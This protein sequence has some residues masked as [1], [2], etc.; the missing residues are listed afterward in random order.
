MTF[1]EMN[2]H[3]VSVLNELSKA[4]KPADPN[5]MLCVICSKSGKFFHG[6]ST[7][8]VAA[9]KAAFGAMLATGETA[10]DSLM[11]YNVGS[12]S[13]EMPEKSSIVFIM[14]ADKKNSAASVIMP[15]KSVPFTD[16]GGGAAAAAPAPAPAAEKKNLLLDRVNSLMD[17]IDEGDDDDEEF[18]EE[19]DTKKKKKKRFGFF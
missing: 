19:L 14:T 8:D 7:E 6:F 1:K 13:A 12:K 18:L 10:V 11:L 17:G 3:A 4:K 2:D 16:F 9:E 15:D 5:S